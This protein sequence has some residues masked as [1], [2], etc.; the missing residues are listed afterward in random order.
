[1]Q[2]YFL[3]H[4]KRDKSCS[5]FSPLTIEGKRDATE[6]IK[7]LPKFDEVWCSPYKRCIQ[8]IYPYCQ[9]HNINVNIENGLSE[10]NHNKELKN[11]KDITIQNYKELLLEMDLLHDRSIIKNEEIIN[12]F[13]ET[14][15]RIYERIS[16]FLDNHIKRWK[17]KNILICSHLHC[18]FMLRAYFNHRIIHYEDKPNMGELRFLFEE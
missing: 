5:F 7:N 16:K 2:I 1:M 17:D 11:N 8:T 4:E 9:F 6:L 13:P 18:Y 15:T 3:R 14:N 10:Y 12:D